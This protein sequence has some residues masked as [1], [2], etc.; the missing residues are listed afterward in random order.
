MLCFY[1]VAQETDDDDFVKIN[2]DIISDLTITYQLS[3]LNDLFSDLATKF[4]AIDLYKELDTKHDDYLCIV[5]EFVEK[6]TRLDNLN[7]NQ[8]PV[9]LQAASSIVY[10]LSA[11]EIANANGSAPILS[12]G[13]SL[14]FKSEIP[15]GA[16]LGSSSSFGICVAAAFYIYAK[17]HAQPNFLEYINGLNEQEHWN[18]LNTISSWA[19]LSERIMHGTPSGLDNTICTFGNVLKFTRNPIKFEDVNLKSKIYIMLVNTNVSRKTLEIVRSVRNLRDNHT[20]L[21]DPIMEAMGFLVDEVIQVMKN[22]CITL[23]MTV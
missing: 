5:N 20:Q 15:P 8:K 17:S 21:I 11:L 22:D 3:L 14:N 6:N 12:K 13:L 19:F 4:H 18:F 16:G 2:C 7:D 10:L 23:N 9:V 1:F